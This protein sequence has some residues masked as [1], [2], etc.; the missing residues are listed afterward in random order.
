MKARA[1]RSVDMMR[2]PIRDLKRDWQRPQ[3]FLRAFVRLR[4][5]A[6]APGLE[7]V[8]KAAD[9]LPNVPITGLDATLTPE[10]QQPLDV[11]KR[12]LTGYFDQDALSMRNASDEAK[13]LAADF[14]ALDKSEL[15]LTVL[16]Q[17][18]EAQNTNVEFLI[19]TLPNPIHSYTGWQFD[20]MLD[21]MAQAI[22]TSDYA[23]DRFH[24]PDSDLEEEST[25]TAA[26]QSGR[27]HE[28]EPGVI[29]FRKHDDGPADANTSERL[30]L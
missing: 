16:R 4:I 3:Q 12:F 2:G 20:P 17:A 18:S 19:A 28:L 5:R 13:L 26:N 30:V 9:E 23:L 1:L 21:A 10:R 29:V 25:G 22:S 27:G 24:F 11:I 8:Q 7:E 6:T 14:E 15:K